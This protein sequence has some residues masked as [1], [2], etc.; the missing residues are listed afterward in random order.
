MEVVFTQG[1]ILPQ[2]PQGR[3]SPGAILLLP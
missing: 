2:E 1:A 3:K